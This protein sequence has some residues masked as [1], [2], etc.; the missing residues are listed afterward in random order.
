MV[1]FPNSMYPHVGTCIP[2]FGFGYGDIE[3]APTMWP[4]IFDP[5][6]NLTK[7]P[8]SV[9]GVTQA[10]IIMNCGGVFA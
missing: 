1:G 7:S 6:P 9:L 5:S 2:Y 10:R 4:L 3:N 8:K